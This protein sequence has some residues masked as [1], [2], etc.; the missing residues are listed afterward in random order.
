[1]VA[2]AGLHMEVTRL[3]GR[4]LPIARGVWL[5]LTMIYTS[6]LVVSLPIYWQK[7]VTDPYKLGRPLALLGLSL[8]NFVV[9][10]FILNFIAIIALMAMAILIF[11]RKSD[12]WMALMVSLMMV[13][14]CVRTNNRCVN[15]PD[16]LL[17][18]AIMPSR[19]LGWISLAVIPIPWSFMPKWARYA[20]TL[21]LVWSFHG[22]SF[23]TWRH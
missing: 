14:R 22:F 1:M 18:S 11:I 2:E 5:G 20:G 16:R 8:H 9:Y 15:K 19:R 10:V 4:R 12:D 7:L 23:L 13:K 6:M 21:V 3:A 17:H